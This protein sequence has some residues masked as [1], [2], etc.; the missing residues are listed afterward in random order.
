LN[1]LFLQFL[2][3]T[4]PRECQNRARHVLFCPPSSLNASKH[5]CK[6]HSGPHFVLV[7]HTFPMYSG[8]LR[9]SEGTNSVPKGI[10]RSPYGFFASNIAQAKSSKYSPWKL[11]HESVVLS[12]SCP[13]CP[14]HAPKMFQTCPKG[15]PRCPKHVPRT[16]MTRRCPRHFPNH[17]QTWPKHHPTMHQRCPKYDP[18]MSQT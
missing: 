15:V 17:F 11:L 10:N 13:T 4:E 12:R 9:D 5:C 1:W 8:I 14:K 3:Q 7:L 2:V 16:K 6:A 18:T